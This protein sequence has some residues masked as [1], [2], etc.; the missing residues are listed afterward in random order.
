MQHE[1]V[2]VY[3]LALCSPLPVLTIPPYWLT[4]QPA[5][6]HR[7]PHVLYPTHT[8]SPVTHASPDATMG[9]HH[10]VYA[11]AATL[12]SPLLCSGPLPRVPGPSPHILTSH[13]MCRP[14]ST[15]CPPVLTCHPP[16]HAATIYVPPPPPQVAPAR[17]HHRCHT[18]D[19]AFLA[20]HHTH[21]APQSH[22]PTT[23]PPYDTPPHRHPTHPHDPLSPESTRPVAP[24]THLQAA[25]HTV[26][27]CRPLLTPPPR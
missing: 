15:C 14:P 13:G 7:N 17:T 22:R 18:G 4:V 3:V 6:H 26:H 20:D 8:F 10:P 11:A 16:L 5:N 27:T 1:D 19:V 2:Q 12:Y 25:P 9:C 21:P 23:M 24:M